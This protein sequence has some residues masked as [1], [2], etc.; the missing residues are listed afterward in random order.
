LIWDLILGRALLIRPATGL[1]NQ[2]FLFS[3]GKF[4]SS[5]SNRKL[6][7][8]VSRLQNMQVSHGGSIANFKLD[9]EFVSLL[10]LGPVLDFLIP[11]LS[12]I[13][14]ISKKLGIY[15]AKG[16]GFQSD[17]ERL[18]Q[19]IRYLEG[20]FMCHNYIEKVRALGTLEKLQLHTP[21]KWIESTLRELNSEFILIH[22]RRGDFLANPNAWGILSEQYYLDS[23]KEIISV[24]HSI[25][26]IVVISDNI[27][28]VQSEFRSSV[29]EN[30]KFLDTSEC[31]PAELMTLF[32]H[33]SSIVIGNSTFSWWGSLF[34]QG[35]KIVAPR[36][37][38][39]ST[40]EFTDLD[41]DDFI[42]VESSWTS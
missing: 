7:V 34:K 38:Y 24:S 22:V 28:L 3:A 32:E 42:F 20:F 16:V 37:F 33:A 1:G 8:D 39:R 15:V 17:L 13:P 21:S 31:N 14:F 40:P 10:K 9:T 25:K 2:L 29:W 26:N 6:Y 27:D 35:G 11:R 12:R 23:I 41:R 30:A 4:V 36:P 19:G 5:I 18:S